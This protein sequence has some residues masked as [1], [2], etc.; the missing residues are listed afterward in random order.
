MAN[1]RCGHTSMA[2]YFGLDQSTGSNSIHDWCNTSSHRT[3]VLRNPMDRLLSA[4]RLAEHHTPRNISAREWL[5]RHSGPY[6]YSLPIRWYT[7]TYIPF[8][9][10]HNYIP[11]S[12]DNYVTHS[13]ADPGE[14]VPEY[15]LE[16]MAAYE[17]IKRTMSIL[18]PEQWRSLTG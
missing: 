12:S 4:I 8:E 3:M 9:Q 11:Y 7:W 17:T 18:T 6:L 15:L 13:V 1:T 10:L 14:A 2:C 16:E 5:D